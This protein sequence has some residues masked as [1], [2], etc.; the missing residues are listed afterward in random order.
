MR[1]LGRTHGSSHT[2]TPVLAYWGVDGAPPYCHGQVAF[3]SNSQ[4]SHAYEYGV[5]HAGTAGSRARCFELGHRVRVTFSTLVVRLR[6]CVGRSSCVLCTA[7]PLPERREL[8]D[9]FRQG[10][11][12]AHQ[13]LKRIQQNLSGLLPGSTASAFTSVIS[14]SWPFHKRPKPTSHFL[15]VSMRARRGDGSLMTLSLQP[16]CSG[17]SL[18]RL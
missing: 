18:L 16:M 17:S 14:R 11:I 12:R 3:L 13:A 15:R 9:K 4:N 1:L 2:P 8:T 6:L 7:V 5:P 10:A